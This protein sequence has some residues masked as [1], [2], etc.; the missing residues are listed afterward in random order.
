MNRTEPGNKED[1]F[2]VAG[3]HAAVEIFR[4]FKLENLACLPNLRANKNQFPQGCRINRVPKFSGIYGTT[5][6]HNSTQLQML[7]TCLFTKLHGRQYMFNKYLMHGQLSPATSSSY[8]ISP[9]SHK[10]PEK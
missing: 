3:H 7:C 10:N 4:Y 1:R 2:A 6:L 9:L 5:H 8:H